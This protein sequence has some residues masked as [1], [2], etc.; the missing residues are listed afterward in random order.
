MRLHQVHLN[1]SIQVS[2]QKV[3]YKLHG[4]VFWTFNSCC[5]KK[6]ND[7]GQWS[8]PQKPEE[9]MQTAGKSLDEKET[10]KGYS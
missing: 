6:T 10:A 3:C 7:F 2:N 4:S 8:S 5:T 9:E 1:S